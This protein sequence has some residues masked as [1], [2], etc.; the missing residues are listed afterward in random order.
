[1][2]HFNNLARDRRKTVIHFGDRALSHFPAK[3]NR[4]VPEKRHVI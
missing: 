4:K 1:M 2:R 3:R